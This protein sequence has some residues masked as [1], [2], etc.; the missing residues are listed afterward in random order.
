MA[1]YHSEAT[2]FPPFFSIGIAINDIHHSFL[3]LI[4]VVFAFRG[5]LLVPTLFGRDGG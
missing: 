5:E 4:R 2:V 1:I 3:R